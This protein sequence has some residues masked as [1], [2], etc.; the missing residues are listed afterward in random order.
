[1][2]W[3]NIYRH[4]ASKGHDV[5]SP[6]QHEGLCNS[7]YLVLYE[8]DT[9]GQGGAV[10]GRTLV[11]VMIVNPMNEHSRLGERVQ[12]I[13]D[14]LKELDFVKL[15]GFVSSTIPQTQKKAHSKVI[16]CIVNRRL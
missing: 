2:I 4:L 7:P 5:Y 16:E 10:V 3:S 11:E 6:G 1:M 8:G 14:D 13:K 12:A 15:T 9:K